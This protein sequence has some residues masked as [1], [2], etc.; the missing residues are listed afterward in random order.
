MNN[1]KRIK[2]YKNAIS[3][4]DH[5]EVVEVEVPEEWIKNIEVDDI[6]KDRESFEKLSS[7]Y[8]LENEESYHEFNEN[9]TGEETREDVEQDD[10]RN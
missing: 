2:N 9:E 5:F 3:K 4:I 1:Y 6:L 10:L 7:N 8:D